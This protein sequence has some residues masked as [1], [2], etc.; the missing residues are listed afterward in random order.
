LAADVDHDR[1]VAARALSDNRNADQQLI[2]GGKLEILTHSWDIG[3]AVNESTVIRRAV[4]VLHR[5]A[6]ALAAEQNACQ[7]LRL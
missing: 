7:T 6:F 3:R 5:S 2:A 4:R 1:H